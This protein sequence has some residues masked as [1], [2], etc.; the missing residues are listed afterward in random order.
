MNLNK[1]IEVATSFDV[2]E[3]CV[4]LFPSFLFTIP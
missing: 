2:W 3:I 1:H 4:L